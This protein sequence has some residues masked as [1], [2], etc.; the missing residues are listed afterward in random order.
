MAIKDQVKSK[1]AEAA[2]QVA[3]GGG[4]C[5]GGSGDAHDPITGNL[6][7]ESQISAL[8]EEASKPL[9]AAAIRRR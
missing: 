5:C 4:T 2:N 7:D 1:Y 6:Y 9:W 3:S 8:P